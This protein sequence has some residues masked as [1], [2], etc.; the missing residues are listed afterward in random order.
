MCSA[1][2][3]HSRRITEKARRDAGIFG[4]PDQGASIEIHCARKEVTDHPEVQLGWVATKTDGVWTFAAYVPP[5]PTEQELI[6]QAQLNKW[7]LLNVAANWL[8]LN[9]LQFK[10]ATGVANP[11][12]YQIKRNKN[13]SLHTDDRGQFLQPCPR[14]GGYRRADACGAGR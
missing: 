13:E 3:L 7:Q 1:S 6:A 2:A 14:R 11:D 12:E 8:L 10:V 4:M 5:P 9:S